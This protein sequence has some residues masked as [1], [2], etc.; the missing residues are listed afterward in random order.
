[1]V[2]PHSVLKPQLP[3]FSEGERG[4][5]CGSLFFAMVAF[6]IGA[7]GWMVWRARAVQ[8]ACSWVSIQALDSIHLIPL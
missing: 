5:P 7:S 6:Y 1:M 2:T 4:Q 8:V 3:C